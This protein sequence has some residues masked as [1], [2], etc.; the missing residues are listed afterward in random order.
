MR[1]WRRAPGRWTRRWPAWLGGCGLSEQGRFV[2]PLLLEEPASLA[3]RVKALELRLEQATAGDEAVA[4]LRAIK[5][6]GPVTA[7]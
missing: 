2:V 6:V 1:P 3:A 7:W 5:G 4:Q